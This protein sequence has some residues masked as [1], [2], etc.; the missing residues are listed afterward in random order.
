MV[1]CVAGEN[2]DFNGKTGF[3]LQIRNLLAIF[4]AYPEYHSVFQST[5]TFDRLTLIGRKNDFFEIK[6]ISWRLRCCYWKNSFDLQNSNYLGVFCKKPRV[7]NSFL[8]TCRFDRLTE[9]FPKKCLFLVKI[10]RNVNLNWTYEKIIEKN[11]LT[12]K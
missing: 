11:L 10:A 9:I 6:T 3:D 4:W 7:R 5:C 1:E 2:R 8:A 12:S